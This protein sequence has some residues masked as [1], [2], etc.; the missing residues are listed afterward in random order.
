MFFKY[1]AISSPAIHEAILHSCSAVDDINSARYFLHQ[2]KLTI[3]YNWNN[4]KGKISEYPEYKVCQEVL[5]RHLAKEYQ[6]F[7]I[8]DVDRLNEIPA[9]ILAK[10]GYVYL[11]RNSR[12]S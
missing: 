4:T 6:N 11:D 5:T 1:K 3:I 2:N 8:W 7:E 12:V 10:T 9:N